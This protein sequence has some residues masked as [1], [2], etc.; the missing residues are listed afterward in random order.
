MV[1]IAFARAA[2]SPSG[3]Q[4]ASSLPPSLADSDDEDEEPPLT[5]LQ[6]TQRAVD[7]MVAIMMEL[8]LSGGRFTAKSFCT[9]SHWANEAG[10]TGFELYRFRPDAPSGQAKQSYADVWNA[11]C[12]AAHRK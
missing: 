1:S 8:Y 12:R 4:S 11:V 6:K 2:A 5:S 7:E 9:I 3:S 10:L